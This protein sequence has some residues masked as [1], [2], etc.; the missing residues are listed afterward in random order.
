MYCEQ[1]PEI[2]EI[3]NPQM[4]WRNPYSPD[5]SPQDPDDEESDPS[6]ANRSGAKEGS[7]IEDIVE[8]TRVTALGGVN[9]NVA[10]EAHC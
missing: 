2:L 3:L 4:T 8:S 6:S 9:E 7:E 10:R 5:Q 1:L